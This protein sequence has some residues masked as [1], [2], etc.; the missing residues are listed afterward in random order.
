VVHQCTAI[1]FLRHPVSAKVGKI[2]SNGIVA[3]EAPERD[4]GTLN[5][6]HA[7][8]RDGQRANRH[9]ALDIWWSMIF[10]ESRRV[11]FFRVKLKRLQMRP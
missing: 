9:R 1:A 4:H 5:H 7:L 8:E 10:S 3:E 11:R 2:S 6:H